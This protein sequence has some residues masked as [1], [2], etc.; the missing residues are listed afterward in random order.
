ML[1]IN[2]HLAVPLAEI[3]LDAIR[4]QG[5]G[6]QKVNK[7]S[8][9]VHLRFDIAGSSL[10]DD[11]KARLLARRDRRLSSGGILVIKAQRHRT[12]EANRDDAL[13]RLAEIIQRAA[14]APVKRKATRPTRGAQRRRVD[15]K[16]QRG[17]VKALRSRI[18]D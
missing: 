4:A 10:P 12:Q 14:T 8:S 3:E 17:R 9:A 11:C 16:V 13:Q 7:T 18:D 2:D 15:T 1:Q 6:G 5:A